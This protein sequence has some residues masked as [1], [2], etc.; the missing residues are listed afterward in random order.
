MS[1]HDIFF[2]LLFSRYFSVSVH[3]VGDEKNFDYYAFSSRSQESVVLRLREVDLR[4]HLSEEEMDQV[5]SD[6][7]HDRRLVHSKVIEKLDFS[8]QL[9]KQREEGEAS[10]GGQTAQRTSLPHSRSGPHRQKGRG[11]RGGDGIFRYREGVKVA[12]A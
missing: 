3:R 4:R 6:N 2:L 12:G 10:G 5:L 11:R 9:R 8:S 7:K 1:T